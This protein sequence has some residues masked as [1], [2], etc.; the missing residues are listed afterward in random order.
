MPTAGPHPSLP[1]LVVSGEGGP[2]TLATTSCPVELLMPRMTDW[3]SLEGHTHSRPRVGDRCLR[4]GLFPSCFR[5][6]YVTSK[7][8]RSLTK[9]VI[10]RFGN[11]YLSCY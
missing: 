11:Q 6:D 7:G 2:P 9:T 3:K 10:T 1:L 4:F 8:P 5:T